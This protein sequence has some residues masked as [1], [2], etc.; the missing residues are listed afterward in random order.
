MEYDRDIIGTS[1]GL[2]F[3]LGEAPESPVALRKGFWCQGG[4]MHIV[5]TNN[6]LRVA[7][8]HWYKRF[9]GAAYIFKP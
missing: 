8:H 4:K 3:S 1:S 7:N 9:F 5:W 6:R 2:C